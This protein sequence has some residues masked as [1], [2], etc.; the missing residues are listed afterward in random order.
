MSSKRQL[1]KANLIDA[2]ETIPGIGEVS[3]K[4]ILF[5]NVDS[6]RMPMLMVFSGEEN[7]DLVNSQRDTE[8]EWNV[9]V[10]A[11]LKAEDDLETWIELVRAKI[12]LDRS[13][14][15]TAGV[16]NALDTFITKIIA[17]DEGIGNIA[18]AF[19]M[20][21]LETYRVRE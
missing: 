5:N 1:I 18:S 17:D 8:C 7:R 19:Q 16:P 4:F 2:L 20:N 12:M 13:R 6:S 21:V 10:Q 9:L 15:T 11:Y 14:G 3:D